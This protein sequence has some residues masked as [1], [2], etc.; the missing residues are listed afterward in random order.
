MLCLHGNPKPAPLPCVPD[1]D[2]CTL[3]PPVCPRERPL[4][5][6]TYGSYKCRAP[7]R[8]GPGLEPNDE[9]TA[10][11]GEWGAELKDNQEVCWE[12]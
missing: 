6:N 7:K 11:V 5:I 2:E 9:G 3:L 8:C 10:C 12:S 1:Q 4:C